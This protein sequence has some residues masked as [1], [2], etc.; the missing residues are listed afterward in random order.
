MRLTRQTLASAIVLLLVASAFPGLAHADGA[1]AT[2]VS[3]ASG[4][5]IEL[6][7]NVT[8]RLQN[9]PATVTNAT[10]IVTLDG[11]DAGARSAVVTPSP[12]GPTIN[13]TLD[14]SGFSSGAHQLGARVSANGTSVQAT[15]IQVVLDLAPLVSASGVF[16]LDTRSLVAS[17]SVHDEGA[18]PLVTLYALGASTSATFEGTSPMTLPLANATPGVHLA[19]VNVTDS[20]G[21]LVRTSFTFDVWDRNATFSGVVAAYRIGG[22]VDV[23][24]ASIVDPDGDISQVQVT[25]NGSDGGRLSQAADGSWNG[26][27][28]IT[29]KLG[30]MMGSITA[31]DLHTGE[32]SLVFAFHVGGPVETFYE[33]TWPKQLV[34]ADAG[35]DELVLPRLLGGTISICVNGCVEN[36]HFVGA[37]IVTVT[38]WDGLLLGELPRTCASKGETIRC[39]FEIGDPSGG[40]MFVAW[41]LA[42]AWNVEVRVTGVRV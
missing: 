41:S 26:T 39:A 23:H 8:I 21:H 10:A 16:D 19:I 27:F 5:T 38:P 6:R 4:A 33:R 25:I 7:S 30:D 28:A 31:T 9:F 2:I 13:V 36:T 12:L 17:I 11:I 18:A 15:P 22:L 3:P 40:N 1:S 42:H 35:A 24:V 37:G 20:A 14:A 29:P 34:G 32:T